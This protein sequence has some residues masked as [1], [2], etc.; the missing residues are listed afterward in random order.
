MFVSYPKLI[1]VTCKKKENGSIVMRRLVEISKNIIR[2]K[3]TGGEP[4]LLDGFK[5]YIKKLVDKGYAKDITF[6]T[7]TNGTVDCS[8]LL[9]YM[10]EFKEFE[11]D[12]SVDGTGKVYDY[13]RW[14][15]NFDRMRRIHEKLASQ[16]INNK[17]KNIKIVM[18]PTIQVWNLHNMPE[19]IQY[20]KDIQI[21]SQVDFGHIHR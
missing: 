18:C 1:S 6:K 9:P 15:G 17:Y 21:V 3:S 7:V 5:G 14:P 19:M 4:M 13:I 8:D 11:M 20:A 10:N 2:V 12:W 16:I